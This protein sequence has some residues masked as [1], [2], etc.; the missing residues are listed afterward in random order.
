MRKLA[1]KVRLKARAREAVTEP[2]SQLT[3]E[4][5]KELSQADQKTS[6]NALLQKILEVRKQSA[7]A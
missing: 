3:K 4:Q 5:I 2:P 7:G 1:T 6:Y